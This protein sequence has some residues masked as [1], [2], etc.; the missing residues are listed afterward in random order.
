MTW[1][2]E[3]MILT[4]FMGLFLPLQFFEGQVELRYS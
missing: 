4:V 3:D 1:L 2:I